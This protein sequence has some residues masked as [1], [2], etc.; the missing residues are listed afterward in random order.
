MNKYH[1]FVVIA[2]GIAIFGMLLFPPYYIVG[3]DANIN[4]GYGF[5]F[6]PPK[7]G[8]YTATVNTGMLIVQWLAVLLIGGIVLFLMKDIKIDQNI[9]GP[10]QSQHFDPLSPRPWY[11]FWARVIDYTLYFSMFNILFLSLDMKRYFIT[12]L[13][14][15]EIIMWYLYSIILLII[16]E[17]TWL[18]TTATTPGKALFAIKVLTED[19]SKLSF[20]QALERS[21]I[22]LSVGFS[23]F[24]FFPIMPMLTMW[25]AYKR[26]QRTGKALWDN[27][28]N[29]KITHNYIGKLRFGIGVG[30]CSIFVIYILTVQIV[31]KQINEASRRKS[32]KVQT[33]NPIPSFHQRDLRDLLSDPADFHR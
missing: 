32:T 4:M 12:E 3:R 24:V 21:F 1:K 13:L 31:L 16:Y 19:G 2:A 9:G 8:I 22:V 11:R 10:N 29:F 7:R 28:G 6:N 27:K 25:S 26:I 15:Q 33:I 18:S 17:A 5:I 23:F 14:V 20:W 30:L